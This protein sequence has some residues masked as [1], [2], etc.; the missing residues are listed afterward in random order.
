M[1]VIIAR[2][3]KR[4]RFHIINPMVGDGSSSSYC[5]QVMLASAGDEIIK[6]ITLKEIL[7]MHK[8]GKMCERCFK[9]RFLD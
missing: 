7:L 1:A 4:K 6:D 8:Q 3:K 5:G 2:L 9:S